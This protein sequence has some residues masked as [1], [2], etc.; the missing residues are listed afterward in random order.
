[1]QLHYQWLRLQQMGYYLANGIYPQLAAFVKTISDPKATNKVTS[2]QCKRQLGRMWRGHPEFSKLFGKLFMELQWYGNQ[3]LWQLMTCCVILHNMIV[4]D[5]GGGVSQT[6]YFETS[7]EQ[8][9]IPEDQDTDQLMNFLWMHQNL[10][11][12]H[13]HAQ[14]F[15]DFVK[16]MW[17]Q[18]DNQRGNVWIMHLK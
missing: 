9:H 7:G 6:N 18:N 8:V 3:R 5:E 4:E 12:H 13:V 2:Q 15:S 17:T 14:L 1:M 11:N 10:S 16:H